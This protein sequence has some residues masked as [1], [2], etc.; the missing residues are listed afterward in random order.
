MRLA[1]V[2]TTHERPDALA[3]VLDSVARQRVAPDEIVI[4][5]DGSG[6]ATRQ[7]IDAFAAHSTVPV[8]R[9]SQPHEGFRAARLP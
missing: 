8:H 9:V 5:D 7:V 2:I 6:V 4:A 3:A 1:L